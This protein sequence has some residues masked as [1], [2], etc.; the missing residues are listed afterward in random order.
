M[1]TPK[2]QAAPAKKT[3]GKPLILRL[4][5]TALRIGGVLAP[6]YTAN[7]VRRLLFTPQRGR[8][9][10]NEAQVLQA[11]A[12]SRH[13]LDGE[14]VCHYVWG[15]GDKRAVLVHGWSGHAGQM[16]SFVKP[17]VD[18]GWQVIA[19][20]LP[21]HGR[22]GGKTASI[23]HFKKA[24]KQAEQVHGRF[25][26]VVA[27]SLGAA[28]IALA[29]LKGEV[30]D[31]AVFFGPVTRFDFVWQQSMDLL[32]ISQKLMDAAVLNA[33]KWLGIRFPEITPENY[34]QGLATPLLV[35]HDRNDYEVP[36]DCGQ[37]LTAVWPG[38]QLLVTEK[39]G[40][41]KVLH[42]PQAIASTVAFLDE[43]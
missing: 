39:L 19:I 6:G 11:A 3:N 4:I 32:G 33:E 1:T 13:S 30:F 9:R 5:S 2:P 40:H 37:K 28:S 36:L 41:V 20:D 17:L 8:V 7:T 29:L 42:D 15:S 38:S 21:A 16:T 35:V 22:S 18:A 12:V 14:Q 10:P 25:H 27:H 24:L 26:G 23:I 34:A 31:R 43:R